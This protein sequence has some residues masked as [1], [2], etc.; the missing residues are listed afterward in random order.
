MLPGFIHPKSRDLSSSSS[1]LTMKFT[2]DKRIYLQVGPHDP[3]F[4]IDVGDPYSGTPF[5]QYCMY[6]ERECTDEARR[7]CDESYTRDMNELERICSG[8]WGNEYCKRWV[9][10]ADTRMRNC[11]NNIEYAAS[12][13]SSSR[14]CSG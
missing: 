4:P 11:T 1:S 8:N 9:N 6:V 13:C 2:N 5:S 7:N 14:G 3:P 10:E 12:R